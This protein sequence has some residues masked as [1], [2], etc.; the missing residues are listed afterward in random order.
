MLGP[1]RVVYGTGNNLKGQLTGPGNLRTAFTSLA[2]LPAGVSATAIAASFTTSLVL[3]A[4]GTVYGAGSNVEGQLTGG[5]GSDRVTPLVPLTGLPAGVQATAIAAG[6]S[7]TLIAGSDGA[8]YGTGASSQ[9]QLTDTAPV[10]RSF[11]LVR[12][13]GLPARTRAIAVAAGG[14]HTLVID[15]KGAVYGT[16]HN[17]EG[18][19]TGLGSRTTLTPLTGPLGLEAVAIA[20]GPAHSLVLGSTGAV[21]GTGANSAG[22]LTGTGGGRRTTLTPM[23]GLPVEVHATAI[24]TGALHSL[25]LGSDGVVYGAGDNSFGQLTGTGNRA[26]LTPLIG[27]PDGVEAV[28]IA[29]RESH[30]LVL[31]NNGTVYGA[32]RNALGQL[33]GAGNRAFLTPLTGLPEDVHATA[34]AA[35]GSHSLVSASNGVV[36]GTG[37]NTSGQLTGTANRTTLTPLT[38]TGPVSECNAAIAISAGTDFSL[39]LKRCSLELVGAGGNNRGELTGADNPRRA[40]GPVCCLGSVGGVVAMSASGHTVVIGADGGVYGTGRNEAGQL[41]GTIDSDNDGVAPLTGLTAIRA[42][43]RAAGPRSPKV[44]ALAI[45]TGSNS[46]TLVLDNSGTVFGTGDNHHG[47][48]TSTAPD[49]RAILARLTGLPGDVR[50]KAVATGAFHSLVLGSNG[51][52]YGT[53]RNIAGELTGTGIRTNLTQLTG[54]P[55]GVRA[56][57]LAAGNSHSLVLADDG[58]VYGTGN[59]QSGQLTGTGNR[60]SLTALAGLPNGVRAIAI[61]AGHSF[62]LVLDSG[63]NVWG[64]GDNSD[65]QLTGADG[66]RTL[67]SPLS[68]LPD[69]VQAVGIAA[70]FLHSL[71]LGSD[72]IVYGTGNNSHGQLTGVG[73]RDTLTPLAGLPGGIQATAIA[74]ARRHSLV[75]GSNGTAYGTGDNGNGQLTGTGNRTTLTPLDGLP[76]GVS[77]IATGSGDAFSL[78]IGSDGAVYGTGRNEEGQLTGA[79][80]RDRTILTRLTGL[81]TI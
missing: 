64:T 50:A 68:G 4:N 37:N 62:S 80:P 63:G 14:A 23:T 7:H 24:T 32:G 31:G 53:G 34:I 40:L 41:T 75:V 76:D 2:G 10:L 81:P 35:G 22:Q 57:G 39:I 28:A 61:A 42:S 25:V 43:L 65:G 18:Q 21:Y 47:Q 58:A 72:G 15:S 67:L 17:G 44:P 60:V 36:Y 69:G 55:Q 52:V 51:A 49:N 48:L 6:S 3:G 77:A 46:H 38:D 33:T 56:T 16:G 1:D 9:G 71:V 45:A 66:H 20:A 70:G 5:N 19:L 12:L 78:V 13:S 74:A 73:S 79:D 59:N 26:T 30:T 54:L 29:A 27:L 11:T 8:V